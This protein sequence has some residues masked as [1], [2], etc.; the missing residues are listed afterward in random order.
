VLIDSSGFPPARRLSFALLPSLIVL[1]FANAL[2]PAQAGESVLYSFCSQS[3]CT[4]GSSPSAGLISGQ[5]GALYGTTGNGGNSNST[6]TAG[7]GTVFK[8]TPPADGPGPGSESVLYSFCPT[9]TCVDGAFP[10]AGL[11]S[12][13]QGA[14]YGTTNRGGNSNCPFPALCGTVFKLTPPAGAQGPWTESVLY[15]FCM[16]TNCTD[17]TSPTAALT[18]DEQGALYGTTPSGGSSSKGTVFKLTPPT[19]GETQWGE[20]ALYS[21]CSQSNCSDGAYP[22]PG[23][24]IFDRQGALYG[25]TEYGGSSNCPSEIGCGTVYKLTPPAGEGAQ[26][27]ESVL[28]SFCSQNNCSDGAVPGDRL[29]FDQEGALYGTTSQG[30]SNSNSNCPSGCGTVFKL[31]PPSGEEAQWTESVLYDFCSLNSCADGSSPIAG[32]IFDEEGALYGTTSGGGSSN[33][34]QG[35]GTAFKLTRPAA[36][37]MHWT[38]SVLHGFTGGSDGANPYAVLVAGEQGALYSTT[39]NGG[40]S[41]NGGLGY[42]TVF[43]LCSVEGGEAFGGK[44]SLHCLRW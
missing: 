8:L 25:M 5:Q 27:T 11:I 20:S 42:G 26:W 19:G 21:F 34:S 40:S 4:D 33:C 23:P 29:I 31:T 18:F 22:Y 41:G 9:G 6:C 10:V 14:L 35:C 32:L 24:L 13:Q 43:R 39:T 16:Q 30:G 15:S 28:Y 12:D 2:P 3:N 38:E 36:G 1:I 7:C 44:S 17:G 37:E